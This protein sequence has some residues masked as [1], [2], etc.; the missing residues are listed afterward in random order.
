MEEVAGKG[1]DVQ[2]EREVVSQNRSGKY[3]QY[4]PMNKLSAYTE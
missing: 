1:I 2:Y 4:Y 3:P